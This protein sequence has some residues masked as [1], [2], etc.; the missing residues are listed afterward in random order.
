MSAKDLYRA[1]LNLSAK[2]FGAKFTKVADARIRFHKKVNLKNP[3]TLTDKLCYLELFTEDPLKTRCTDKYAVRDYVA[4]KGLE[5]ILVPLCHEV[6]SEVSEIRYD[7]L[8]Q[9]FV[10]KAT[11]GC[12]MNYICADKS[13]ASREEICRYAQK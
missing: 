5:D 12:G 13:K 2:L 3:A 11:H 9:Q 8:P 7:L 10:M 6:C 1:M 4:G